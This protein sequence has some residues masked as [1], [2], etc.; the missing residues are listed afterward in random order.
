MLASEAE[1]LRQSCDQLDAD[2][3]RALVAC[4]AAES[5]GE[6]LSCSGVEC[7]TDAQC[8]PASPSCLRPAQVV[9]PF[10]D[11]PYTCR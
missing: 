9:D 10:N 5:C 1:A 11:V 3:K 8:P 6:L 7:F 4:N 2:S